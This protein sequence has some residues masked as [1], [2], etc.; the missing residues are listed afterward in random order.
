MWLSARFWKVQ[1]LGWSAYALAGYVLSLPGLA[2]AGAARH[3]EVLQFKGSRSLIGLVLSVGMTFAFRRLW[4]RRP[5]AWVLGLVGVVLS[6]ALGAVWLAAQRAATGNRPIFHPEFTHDLLNYTIVMLAWSALFLSYAYRMD[7]DAERERALRALSLA[8]EARWQMLRY[9]V[10]PHFLFNSLNSIRAL[11]DE[12][13][14]RAR[15]MIT[16]LADF[17]R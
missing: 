6:V 2:G 13:P 14:A 1:F 8:S 7:L 10:H 17:F 3:L 4:A 16:E 11:V 5:P 15:S 9:Q 12:D